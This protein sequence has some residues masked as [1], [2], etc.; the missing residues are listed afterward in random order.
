MCSLSRHKKIRKEVI[1]GEIKFL[2]EGRRKRSKGGSEK[3]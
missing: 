1:S 3:A 2:P